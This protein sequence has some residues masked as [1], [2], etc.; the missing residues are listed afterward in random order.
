MQSIEDKIAARKAR[1]RTVSSSP[2]GPDDQ[3]GM[4][5]LISPESM[6]AALT[7]VDGG[8]VFDLSV[9]Y[10]IGMPSWTK[11]GDP[12]FQ[13]FMSARPS[14]EVIDDPMGIGRA[15]NELASRSGDCLSMYTHTGTHVDTLNHIGYRG[16]ILERL[17]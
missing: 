3:I 8:R 9:E 12:P 4:L 14:G 7:G 10:F 13:L 11:S 16:T 2:F 1:F 15:Q 5:N 17:H 6:T